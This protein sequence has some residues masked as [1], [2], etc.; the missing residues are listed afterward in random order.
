MFDVGARIRRAG[1]RFE[2]NE[3][4]MAVAPYVSVV[5]A[6]RNRAGLL[7]DM[8]AA[9][10]DQR[11]P[12]DRFEVIVADNGSGDGT[13]AVVG[14]HSS[15]QNGPPIRYVYVA[16]P[17]KSN[18]V[19]RGLSQAQ[20]DLLAF[21]DDDVLPEPTWIE[22]LARAFDDTGADFAAGRILPIW[23]QPPPSWMSPVLYGALAIPDNGERRLTI[24]ADARH[25]PMPIGANMAVRRTVVE[26]IGGLRSDLGKLAGTLRTGEDHEF[27]LR[28]TQAGCRGVYEPT[29]LVR[30]RV[31]AERLTRGYFRR[32]L[33]QNGRDVARL[34]AAYTAGTRRWLAVPRYLWRDAALDASRGI[35]AAIAG[36][37]RQRFASAVRLIW[38]FGYVRETWFGRPLMRSDTPRAVEV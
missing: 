37:A 33:H 36:D 13:A 6:T 16:E 7:R 18:A 10:A 31:S 28:M 24:G 17:G 4:L 21:T 35:K 30:H 27:F 20:G 1:R 34:E 14:E 9:L 12:R 3:T 26:R 11:W 15:R 8:L 5:V 2:R 25:G 23:E 22:R 29:A 32:W 38:F 19:N